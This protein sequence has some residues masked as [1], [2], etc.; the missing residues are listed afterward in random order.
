MGYNEA[1]Q[2]EAVELIKRGERIRKKATAT[3]EEG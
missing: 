3:K 1:N 2:G